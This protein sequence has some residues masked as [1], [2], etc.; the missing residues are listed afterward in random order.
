MRLS[1]LDH[2]HRLRAR[3]FLSITPCMSRVDSPDIVKMHLYRP[4]FFARPLL[5]LTAPAMR[6]HLSGPQAKLS[7]KSSKI[8]GNTYTLVDTERLI[9][10]AVKA[11]GRDHAE[12]VMILIHKRAFE[13]IWDHQAD[14]RRLT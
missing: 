14:F 7:W 12:A 10:E 3:F 11:P 1:V 2:G 9:R 8:E 5:D 4:G 6:G 13:H